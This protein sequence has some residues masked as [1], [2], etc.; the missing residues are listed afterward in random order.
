MKKIAV[1]LILGLNSSLAA[2]QNLL[3]N[4]I[5]IGRSSFAFGLG[6]IVNF[7]CSLFSQPIPCGPPR[8]A[9]SPGLKLF[10]SSPKVVSI[11]TM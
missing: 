4:W 6:F 1:M 10:F 5:P 2:L 7:V 3:F 8:A 11:D 9:R